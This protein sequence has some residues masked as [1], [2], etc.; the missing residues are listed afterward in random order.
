[1]I[2]GK[3]RDKASFGYENSQF[4]E[5]GVLDMERVLQ[6][7]QEIMKAEYRTEDAKNTICLKGSQKEIYEITVWQKSWDRFHRESVSLYADGD[8]SFSLDKR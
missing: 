4:V 5:N 1:M 3:L 6:K 2:V 7:F 8:G